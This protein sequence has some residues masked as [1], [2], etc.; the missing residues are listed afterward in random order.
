[1]REIEPG[2]K[3]PQVAKLFNETIQL[4]K[5]GE[6]ALSPE[7]FLDLVM[8][9]KLGGHGYQFFYFYFK[10][11]FQTE[12]EVKQNELFAQILEEQER[13]KEN[14]KESVEENKKENEGETLKEVADKNN[15]KR[16]LTIKK[17]KLSPQRRKSKSPSPSAR[18]TSKQ[19]ER[20][21]SMMRNISPGKNK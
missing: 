6:Q 19:G 8:R 21:P 13:T 5:E 9:H 16:S 17:G 1:M 12:E 4:I 2:F 14:E 15:I 7:A 18:K 20:S 11:L 10:N 3:S